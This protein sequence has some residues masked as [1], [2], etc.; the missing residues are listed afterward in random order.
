M[1]NAI[2]LE[3]FKNRLN[4]IVDEMSLTIVRT[5]ASQIVR[6][7]M[8]FSTALCDARGQIVVQGLGI[9]LHLGAVPPA[10]QTIQD[11]FGNAMRQGDV[12]VLND[13]YS[14]GMHLPDIFMFRPAFA[15]D[16]SLIG[17]SIVIA[18]QA[19]IGG[20]VPGGNAADSTEIFQEGLRIPPLRLFDAGEENVDLFACIRDNVRVPD[21]VLSDIR[22]Q[23]SA[24][25][26]GERALVSLAGKYGTA[27]QANF[28][29]LLDYTERL[30]RTGLASLPTGTW[31][32]EDWLDDNGIDPEPT[33]IVATVTIAQDGVIVDFT[34]SSAQVRGAINC[35]PSYANS[36]AYCALR[37][38][39]QD[40][41]PAN[42]GFFRLI[43]VITPLGSVVNPRFPAAVAARGVTGYRAGDAVLGA[44]AKAVPNRVMA[45]NWGGGTVVALG[46]RRP[47]G[48]RFVFAES[49][50]G[51]W[52]GRPSKDGQEGISH[53]MG[54]M[55]NNPVEQLEAECPMRVLKYE[56]VPDS[57]GPGTYR[58][59][60]ATQREYVF[61]GEEGTLQVRADRLRFAAV[62]VA[63]GLPGPLARNY[64]THNGE[65][66]AMPS[67]FTISIANGD[68]FLHVMAGA[69][70]HGVPW[71]RDP[72]RVCN[73]VIDEKV[74]IAQAGSIYGVAIDPEKM[75][76]QTDATAALRREMAS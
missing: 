74:S 33:H 54:N 46:G 44:L 60:L 64:L 42:Q 10:M 71:R 26:L 9:A 2:E 36:A 68:R 59:G 16:A 75:E 32:G 24:C 14:G 28:D 51:N 65:A 43:K 41:I 1:L 13:P 61:L 15:S 6:E 34:G 48:S 66:R 35:T 73:D 19:D 27:L 38:L 58:G 72:Q 49:L 21:K 3:L 53:P 37:F 55:A 45:G 31:Q 8:D 40:D 50:H 63:G 56:F 17:Y 57:G 25:V 62:P 18:H 5:A 23:F 4:S 20:R 12:Y 47:D 7:S 70:G 22:A 67:K 29:D 11:K 52:G 76:I 30:T 39:I 69:A